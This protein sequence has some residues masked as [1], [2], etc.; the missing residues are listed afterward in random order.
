MAIVKVHDHDRS[1]DKLNIQNS[2]SGFRFGG[3]GL[4]VRPRFNLLLEGH[5]EKLEKL[6]DAFAVQCEQQRDHAT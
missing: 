5:E 2:Q 4:V 6:H 3:S 1:R